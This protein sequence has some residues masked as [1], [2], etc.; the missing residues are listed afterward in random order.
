MIHRK[1]AKIIRKSHRYLGFFL[2]I[3]FLLWTVSGLY[4]SWTNIDD[5]HGD[6]FKN[7][8]PMSVAFS[9]LISPSKIKIKEGIHSLELKVINGVAYYWVNRKK[10][11]NATTGETKKQITK[12]EAIAIAK[13]NM[14]PNLK[15]K[16]IQLITKV[17]KHH[18]YR[19]KPLPAYVISYTHKDQV[20]AYVSVSE[21]KF[22]TIR[23]RGWRW[24]DFLWMTHTMDYQG[25][26]NFNNIILRAF[27]L[28][29]LITVLS[30]FILWFISSPTV[31]KVVRKRNR[32]VL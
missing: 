7:L 21:G 32:A 5:I 10:L 29:G 24:F 26:D 17:G 3:Q 11:Y 28:L 1:K 25:R 14:Q 4:F 19:G 12:E 9:S 30:G 16:D 6:H 23:H 20:K 31:R 13:V 15:I 22:Q 2:G 8:K 18:E 27:S